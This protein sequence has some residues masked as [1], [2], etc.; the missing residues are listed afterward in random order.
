AAYKFLFYLLDITSLNKKDV[1]ARYKDACMA[2]IT[3][4]G[5]YYA[6]LDMTPS[7]TKG[8]FIMEQE[9]FD[10]KKNCVPLSTAYTQ[11]SGSSGRPTNASQGEGLSESGEITQ[12]LESNSKR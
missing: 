7:R 8:S 5:Q 2:G 9:V 11:S 6:A 3:V 4:K 10:F 12:D 1:I